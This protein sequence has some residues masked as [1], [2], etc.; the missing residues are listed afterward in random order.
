M[1]QIIYKSSAIVAMSNDAVKKLALLHPKQ[2]FFTL[3]TSGSVSAWTNNGEYFFGTTG[4]DIA[5][6][7]QVIK[8]VHNYCEDYNRKYR[9]GD[10]RYAYDAQ[11]RVTF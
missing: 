3:E 10:A 7:A 2:V 8:Q 9:N 6:C 5:K 4:E 1:R 11:I